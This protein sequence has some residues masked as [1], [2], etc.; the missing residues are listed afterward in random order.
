[1]S[2]NP[3]VR[4]Q[5][6]L[7]ALSW[8]KGGRSAEDLHR[9][10]NQCMIGEVSLRTIYRDIDDLGSIFPITEEK[11]GQKTY[12]KMLDNF[13]LDKIQCSFAELMAV[14]FMNR[15]LESL[16]SDPVAE[17]GKKLTDRII[18]GL[19]EPQRLYLLDLHQLFRVEYPGDG[20]GSQMLQLIADAIRLQQAVRIRYHAFGA[21]ESSLRIIHPYTIY[22]RSQYYVV[23]WCTVRD[24]LRE[25]RLDRILEAEMLE[26]LFEPDPSFDYEEYNKHCWNALKGDGDYQVVLRFPKAAA[27]YIKEYMSNKADSLRELPGGGLEFTKRVGLLEEILAWVLSMGA[28]VEVVSP[29][30]LAALVRD[31]IREQAE[32]LGLL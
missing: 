1:M 24:S 2:T 13:K 20:R 7:R 31:N 11:R 28:E 32:K 30:E 9:E 15:L 12:F 16:G 4:Q 3:L 6:L 25:F 29:P 23:A 17:A 27:N 18:N 26:T 10:L 14:V 5:F 19:P 22:F 21:K 8:S